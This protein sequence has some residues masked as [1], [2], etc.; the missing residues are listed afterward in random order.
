MTG[1]RVSG[2]LAAP[3]APL[4]DG[5]IELVPLE[6]NHLEALVALGSDPLV[7][8][9]TRVPE[10]FGAKEAEWW[11]GLYE[12]GWG[13]GSR[14]GFAIVARPGGEFLGMVAFVM[15]RLDTGEAEVGYI[16]APEARGRGVASRA[17]SIITAWG[18]DELGLE[19]IEL[20]AD[21][22]NPASL[23]VAERGGYAREGTM[24]NVHF[25]AG[26]RCDMALYARVADS[27]AAA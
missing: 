2:P 7:Q 21:L 6:R 15:V 24:R 22:A 18:L 10:T 17:L 11:L 23:K 1:A 5:A 4:T 25:K 19:R 13:D 8:R 27:D 26:R 3:E 16:V 20:R 9:F 14:A 12:R